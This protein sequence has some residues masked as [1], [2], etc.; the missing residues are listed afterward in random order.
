ML[1]EAW[2]STEVGPCDLRP[3][4]GLCLSFYHTHRS[5]CVMISLPPSP[6]TAAQHPAYRTNICLSVPLA[7]AA[8]LVPAHCVPAKQ[9]GVSL[10]GQIPRGRAGGTRSPQP[11][12]LHWMRS[13]CSGGPQPVGSGIAQ[14]QPRDADGP[15]H[16]RWPFSRSIEVKIT[17]RKIRRLRSS[18]SAVFGA[19]AMLRN[20]H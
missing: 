19:F 14:T 16:C 2:G 15:P 13:L 10:T 1:M 12:C 20:H 9:R 7:W 5:F 8:R 3:S 6:F 18:K 4:R 11:C 17:S